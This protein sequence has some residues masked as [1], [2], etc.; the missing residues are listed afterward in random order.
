MENWQNVERVYDGDGSS[1]K[2]PD[3]T[4]IACHYLRLVFKQPL[5]VS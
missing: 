4:I 5:I 3:S 2:Y 1:P